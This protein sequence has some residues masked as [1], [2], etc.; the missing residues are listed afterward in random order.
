M[1]LS[2]TR[3]SPAAR[4][5]RK[6]N[7]EGFT[8]LELMIALLIL[9]I[10]LGAVAPAFYGVLKAGSITNYKSIANGI[11]VQSTEQ[12]RS[13]AYYDV[14]FHTAPVA[15]PNT[16]SKP[17]VLVGFT[18]PLDNLVSTQPTETVGHVTYSILRCVNW[19][20]STVSG[21]TLAYKQTY[22]KV[23]WSIDGVASSIS[24]T[25]ALY[26]GGNGTYTSGGENDYAPSP[27]TT[28]VG[29]APS[30]PTSVT[31]VDDT[32]SP[33]WVLDVSW[34]AVSGA[35]SYDVWF[36]Q[37]NPGSYPESTM[38]DAQEDGQVTGT[39][40]LL[41]VNPNTNYYV[42]VV[43]VNSSGSS[44]PTSATPWPI[45][46]GPTTATTTTTTTTTTTS[47][48][49]GTTTTTTTST[50]TTTTTVSNCQATKISVTPA[51]AN[52]NKKQAYLNSSDLTLIPNGGSF[53]V[54]V[55]A[56]GS[57]CIPEVAYNS[58]GC[59]PAFGSTS[60]PPS[61]LSS[62]TTAGNQYTFLTSPSTT[63]T[64]KQWEQ[65]IPVINGA[66]STTLSAQ[67]Y[68]CVES[69]NGNSGQCA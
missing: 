30:A 41:D 49:S 46:S 62:Y 67:S 7:G 20:D 35:T 50:T 60:C 58:S 63:W 65:F 40:A 25:S 15:C 52:S 9:G 8:L 12:M 47:V 6:A 48:G 45:N 55:T 69:S 28:I 2:R 31:A 36:G 61:Y 29:T 17:L 51:G 1:S 57:G 14:A 10:V 26:P 24:Q 59:T 33:G 4:R 56:S 5:R 38:S 23:S 32:S 11:A 66:L 19:M 16:D 43:A 3:K 39:S 44:N 37:S 27:T 13:Y 22:V 64:D 54:V 42:Q 18:T 21:D 68:V 53:S 34:P